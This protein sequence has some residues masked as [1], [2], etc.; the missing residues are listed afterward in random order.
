MVEYLDFSTVTEVKRTDTPPSRSVSG[1]GGKLPTSLMLRVGYVWYR[2]Y[3]MCYSNSGSAYITQRGKTL[4]V[5]DGDVARAEAKQ[6]P[7]HEW[8][9]DFSEGEPAVGSRVCGLCGKEHR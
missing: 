1:Y 3:V 8:E 9:P 4:F 7:P 2:V 5:R 6:I